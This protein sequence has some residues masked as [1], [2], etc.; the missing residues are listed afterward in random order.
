MSTGQRTK[1]W[2]AL[3][4]WTKIRVNFEIKK[5]LNVDLHNVNESFMPNGSLFNKI[6]E[7]L[8]KV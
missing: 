7:V 2:L 4:N 6:R 8:Y 5:E 3:T 1:T